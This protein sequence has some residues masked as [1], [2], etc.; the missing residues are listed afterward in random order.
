MEHRFLG[1][2]FDPRTRT[3]SYDDD[4]FLTEEDRQEF[5]QETSWLT[6]E[7]G[8]MSIAQYF[9]VKDRLINRAKK[10]NHG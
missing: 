10:R 9:H 5:K 4:V 3:Y 8:S 2:K 1:R 7:L 6:G